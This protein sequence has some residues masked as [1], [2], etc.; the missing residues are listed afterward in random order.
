MG[1]IV[2]GERINVITKVI[3]KAI[4]ERDKEPILKCAKEQISTGA[5]YLD[6]NIGPSKKDGEDVMKWLVTTLQEN[7]DIPLCL[8]STNHLAIEA[9]L[10]VHR[11]KAIINSTSAARERIEKFCPL[12]SKYNAYIIGLALGPRGMPRDANERCALALDVIMGA[13]EFG[14][15]AEDIFLDPLAQT[16]NGMQEFQMGILETISLFKSMNEPPPRTTVGLTNV[17]QGVPA[18]LKSIL[19]RTWLAM[20]IE[21][22]LDSAIMESDDPLTMEKIHQ[23][24]PMEHLTEDEK[25]TVKVYRGD[26]L[27]AHSYMDH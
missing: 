21:A 1:F 10:K 6:V 17:C 18:H 12:A 24:N 15:P 26:I 14:V 13:Q 3:A 23:E 5:N 8:D 16:V 19:T 9:G 22:G 7:F 11:G 2:I 27:Y 4:E 20:A 25:K